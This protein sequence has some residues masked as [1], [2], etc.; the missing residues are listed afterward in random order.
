VE[1]LTKLFCAHGEL[2]EEIKRSGGEFQF[3]LDCKSNPV[4]SWGTLPHK[5]VEEISRTGVDLVFHPH[6]VRT[7]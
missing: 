6:L 4:F 3:S 5:L 1:W 7:K 2:F